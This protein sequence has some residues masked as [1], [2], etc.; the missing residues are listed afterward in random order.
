MDIV[1]MSDIHFGR[2]DRQAL[3]AL[4]AHLAAYPADLVVVSGDLTQLG[5]RHE[6]ARARDWLARL[7]LP[8][9][10]TPGNH[11]APGLNLLSRLRGPFRRY[12]RSLG[13]F[14]TAFR[15]AKALVVPLRS[16]HGFQWRSD[17]SLGAIDPRHLN[18]VLTLL[19]ADDPG[20]WRFVV[21]HHPLIDDA[22]GPVAGRTRG[23][24]AALRALARAGA[25]F[26]LTG[27][28]H[29]PSVTTFPL[30]GRTVHLIAAGTLSNRRRGVAAS[31][32][33]FRL[34]GD[35]VAMDR[36]LLDGGAFRVGETFTFDR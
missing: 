12:Q 22:E 11:D 3:K 23:G 4:E 16:A 25:D 7:D 24:H 32:N 28:T 34:G 29:V 33:R 36:L 10:S 21:C 19:S 30:D 14:S 18:P 13:G 6:F 5:R 15:N 35:R 8:V 20:G 9:V 1:H 27:H 17:W 2:E 26:V 31:V